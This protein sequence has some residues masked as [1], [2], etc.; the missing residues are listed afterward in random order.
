MIPQRL[1]DFRIFPGN[2]DHSMIQAMRDGTVSLDHQL[3]YLGVDHRRF[4]QGMLDVI[5]VALFPQCRRKLHAIPGIGRRL[6]PVKF[7]VDKVGHAPKE[8]PQGGDDRNSIAKSRPGQLMFPSVEKSEEHNPENPSMR[9]HSSIPNPNN[10]NRVTQHCGKP[11]FRNHVEKDIAET[12]S[13][14]DAKDRG[15]GH[16]IRNFLFSNDP[17]LASRKTQKNPVGDHE[18][19][20]IGQA[21]PA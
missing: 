20:H 2:L 8:H 19:R 4:I 3:L 13:D 5:N 1:E 12:P 10:L 14:K 18:A 11:L 9:R 7:T 16:D 15:V 17:E 21:I 6:G